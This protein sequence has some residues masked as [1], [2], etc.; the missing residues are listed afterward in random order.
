MWEPAPAMVWAP[1][2]LQIR[3]L[4]VRAS[5]FM[6]DSTGSYLKVHLFSLARSIVD[7]VHVLTVTRSSFTYHHGPDATLRQRRRGHWYRRPASVASQL[8]GRCVSLGKRKRCSRHA[9]FSKIRP[10]LTVTASDFKPSVAGEVS[11]WVGRFSVSLLTR[12]V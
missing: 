4:I 10:L 6:S 1:I 5:T 11:Y 2:S 3:R 9:C 7:E 8:R 12:T